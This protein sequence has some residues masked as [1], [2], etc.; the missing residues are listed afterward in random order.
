MKEGRK[1]DDKSHDRQTADPAHK[2]N[3]DYNP[4]EMLR[5]RLSV[6]K[7]GFTQNNV[8]FHST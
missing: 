7:E 3:Q 2:S 4:L 1:K 8:G 6:R 5:N